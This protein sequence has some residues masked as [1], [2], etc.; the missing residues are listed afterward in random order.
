MDL[1]LDGTTAL[2]TGAASGIGRAVVR[3]LAGEG[4]R[5]ALL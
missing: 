3:A 2:V 1:Q 5:V 4:V